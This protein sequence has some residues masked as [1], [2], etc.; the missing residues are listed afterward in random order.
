MTTS[1]PMSRSTIVVTASASGV[2]G[3]TQ[4][5]VPPFT[6][7]MSLTFMSLPSPSDSMKAKIAQS[8]GGAIPPVGKLRD[9]PQQSLN[10]AC[11]VDAVIES[12]L[13][14]CAAFA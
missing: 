7:R 14:R 11:L 4:Y 13:C 1:E 2:C 3:S 5:K 6:R 9:R 10:A 8:A 12:R